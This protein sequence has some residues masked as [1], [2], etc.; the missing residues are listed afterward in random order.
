MSGWLAA[1]AAAALP[2]II[3]AADPPTQP[4]VPLRPAPLFAPAPPAVRPVDKILVLPFAPLN[5][6]DPQVWVGKSV[7]Q[8][9]VADLLVGAPGRIISADEPAADPEKAIALA[10]KAGAGYVVTGNF[11]TSNN[12]LRVTGQIIDVQGGQPVS[13]LMVTGVPDEIFRME[14][15]LAMQIEATLMPDVLAQQQRVAQ[16]NAD[17]ASQPTTNEQYAGVRTDVGAATPTST[18]YS[19]YAYPQPNQY[20]AD[21]NRYYYSY[22]T[23]YSYNTFGSDYGVPYSYGLFSY[24]YCYNSPF[25]G[26]SFGL[27]FFD[28]SRRGFGHFDHGFGHFDHGFRDGNHFEGHH[29]GGH[30]IGGVF[31]MQTTPGITNSTQIDYGGIV[32]GRLTNIGNNPA[33]VTRNNGIS[34]GQGSFAAPA[35]PGLIR[36][37]GIVLRDTPSAPSGRSHINYRSYVPEREVSQGRIEIR[38]SGAAATSSGPAIYE[39]GG[40]SAGPAPAGVRSIGVPAGGPGISVGGGSSGAPAPAVVRSAPAPAFSAPAPSGGG[41]SGGGSSGGGSSSSSHSNSSSGG[42]SSG[43]SGG[44]AAAHHGR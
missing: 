18:Y 17:N 1:L 34:G 9:L 35:E 12:V 5:P 37:H 15:G 21:Y 31:N 3:L 26:V 13:G 42:Q 28:G 19:V 23:I 10:H 32:S 22:P 25:L 40:N 38:G 30:R 39:A 8:S 7:Q 24:P 27:G 20:M 6:A 33:I 43:G 41:S 44:G 11:V 29:P 16:Q 14:D 2:S 36:G 4:A